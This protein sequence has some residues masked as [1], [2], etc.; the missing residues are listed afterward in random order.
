M[1]S[2]SCWAVAGRV[3]SGILL[4]DIKRK[5]LRFLGQAES[6]VA[7]WPLLPADRATSAL[8][9]PCRKVGQASEGC[10]ETTRESPSVYFCLCF[11]VSL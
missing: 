2:S 4:P 3:C 6:W 5:K 7:P 10:W 11:S 8:L 9:V 1:P